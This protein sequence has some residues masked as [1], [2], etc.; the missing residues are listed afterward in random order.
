M[1]ALT[2]LCE[3][4]KKLETESKLKVRPEKIK[5]RRPRQLVVGLTLPLTT[6]VI[7]QDNLEDMKQL[8]KDMCDLLEKR[9]GS[10]HWHAYQQIADIFLSL[11][12]NVDCFIIE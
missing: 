11:V 8:A 4:R 3:C 5:V 12:N 7:F 2:H 1:E 10:A 9:V 6:K